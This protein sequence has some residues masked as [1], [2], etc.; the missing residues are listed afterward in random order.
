MT[1]PVPA[2]PHSADRGM[3]A[4]LATAGIVALAWLCAMLYVVAVWVTE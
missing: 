3:T 1:T 2:P 4:M